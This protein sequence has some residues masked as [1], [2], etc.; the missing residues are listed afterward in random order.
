MSAGVVTGGW[1]FVIAAYSITVAVLAIY[2]VTLITRLREERL[3]VSESRD[4]R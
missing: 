3:R 1:N 4:S 2:G